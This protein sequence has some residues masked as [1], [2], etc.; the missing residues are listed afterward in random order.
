MSTPAASAIGPSESPALPFE[1]VEDCGCEGASQTIRAFM[2]AP[3]DPLT[4]DAFLNTLDRLKP[5]APRTEDLTT[6]LIAALSAGGNG[7]EKAGAFAQASLHAEIVSLQNAADDQFQLSPKT[8]SLISA[9]LYRG[10]IVSRL[11]ESLLVSLRQTLLDLADTGK[12]P[13]SEWLDLAEAMA[14]HNFLNEYIWDEME[15]EQASVSRLIA[16]V[17][18]AI[19]AGEPVSAFEL[20]VIGTYAP[21][22]RIDTVRE[23]VREIGRRDI[24]ALDETLRLVVFDRLMEDAIE[25]Q[26]IT[27]ITSE[28]SLK[29]QSQ[30]EANPY[31]RWR[32]MPP[33][34]VF[35]SLPEYV[36]AATGQSKAFSKIDPLRPKVLVAGAGTGRHP[37]GVAL[38]LPRAVVLA[39]DLSRA[40][41]A[42]ATREAAMREVRNISFAQADIL[43]L[44][45]VA[46]EFHL[47][48][49]C[50]VLHHMEDP[51]A[52]LKSLVNAL[53]PGGYLRLGLYSKTA[54]QAVTVARD[55]FAA[56]GYG[57]DLAGVRAFRRDLL[58]SDDPVFT[59]LQSTGDFFS[60]SEFRDLVMHVQEHQFTLPQIR[61]MLNRNGLKFIGFVSPSVRG[62]LNR[63]P[64]KMAKRRISDLGAWDRFEKRN[65]DTFIGMYDFFCIKR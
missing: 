24:R 4:F 25:I 34:S 60:T 64:D 7:A 5:S 21:L 47:I 14:R 59:S 62:S 40:S 53:K 50:G 11:L 39:I 8:L 6:A 31:P 22:V 65:P 38:T 55:A 45:G 13:A 30:Y 61:A 37:L 28:V 52:G 43:K 1:N 63:M 44:S 26:R 18:R 54:R 58:A 23:W 29:V 57:S 15:A 48:E 36:A 27:P 19:E 20:F 51:E 2:D 49:A 9:F 32:H 12:A 56:G 35:R 17:S 3:D 46:A 42:Y 10:R 16:K 33:Y 41:L